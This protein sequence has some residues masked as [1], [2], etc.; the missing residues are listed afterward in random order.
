MADR[1]GSDDLERR[2]RESR[3]FRRIYFIMHQPF[4]PERLNLLE[5]ANLLVN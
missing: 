2:D 3:T 5:V 1:V 4:D